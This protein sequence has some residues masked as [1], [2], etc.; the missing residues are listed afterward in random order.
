MHPM[1]R[2]LGNKRKG[3]KRTFLQ[4]SIKSQT[5]KSSL[6]IDFIHNWAN[7]HGSISFTNDNDDLSS[8]EFPTIN[9]AFKAGIDSWHI[10]GLTI[11][12]FWM[13][14][15]AI[16]MFWMIAAFCLRSILF[17]RGSGFL[18]RLTFKGCWLLTP[19]CFVVLVFWF[20]IS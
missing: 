14:I 19:F 6:F 3:W 13:K 16:H 11:H 18:F 2:F 7:S 15:D 17:V 4:V 8:N 12:I 9:Y 5:F 1:K 20:K 10:P